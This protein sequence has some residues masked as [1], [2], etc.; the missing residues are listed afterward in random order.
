MTTERPAYRIPTMAEVRALPLNGYRVCSTFSGG[1]GSTLGLRMAGFRVAY[2]NEF[3]AA[4]RDTYAANWPDTPLDPRDIRQV[5]GPEMLAIAGLPLTTD[6]DVLEGS[7][8]CA[9][10][11]VAGVVSKGWNRQKDYSD[12][13]RQRVDDLFFEFARLV[14]DLRPRT[15]VAENVA[16]LVMGHSRGYFLA[17]LDALQRPG[18]TVRAEVLDAKWLGVPQERKRLI[19][20]GVRNDLGM[21]PIF[22]KPLP[23]F[24]TIT[25]LFPH[26]RRMRVAGGP[27]KWRWAN[28]RPAATITA[29]DGAR[30][31]QTAYMSSY[32]IETMQGEIRKWTV[33]ELRQL[34]GFPPDY[35]LTGSEA[36]QWE[37]IGRAVPPEVYRRVG[38]CL[39][40]VLD[41]A[42]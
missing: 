36:Q 30:T 6:I 24:H 3:I 16:G 32:L 39:Q 13:A 38:L 42:R 34:A 19:F 23:Y 15:F 12:N 25:A 29:S 33:D 5:T 11:S 18:Y 9:A 26:I 20:I 21:Q 40:G 14:G 2:A 7:P 17:I 8:P 4:A 22:P 41:A 1:G 35:I 28:D 31:N 10:F 37:R 27:A